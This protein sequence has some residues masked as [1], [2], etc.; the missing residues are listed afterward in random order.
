M[1]GEGEGNEGIRSN[2]RATTRL[3]TLATQASDDV[4]KKLHLRNYEKG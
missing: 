4:T 2:F 3:E 1:T